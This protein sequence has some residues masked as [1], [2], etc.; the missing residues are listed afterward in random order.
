MQ[1]NNALHQGPRLLVPTLVD[2]MIVDDEVLRKMRGDWA[3]NQAE[4]NNVPH[5][6]PAFPREIA[7][8]RSTGRYPSVKAP[9]KG[10][11]L[12]WILPKGLCRGKVA[13]S[14]KL[15]F[16]LVPNRWLVL[17][18]YYDEQR[19][20]QLKGWVIR[21]DY[22]RKPTR[23][24][25]G[26]YILDEKE[27]SVELRQIGHVTPLEAWAGEQAYERT[28]LT[29]IGPKDFTFGNYTV[30]NKNV[31]S[32]HDDL[33][34]LREDHPYE[35]GYLV[36]GWFADETEDPL[37]QVAYGRE[38]LLEKLAFLKFDIGGEDG[39]EQ[40]EAAFAEAAGGYE[41]LSPLILCHGAIHSIRWPWKA[42]D[43]DGRPQK[44]LNDAD[45]VPDI[46]VGNSGFDTLATFIGQEL[47][48]NGLSEKETG[49][50][51]DLL[52]AF[53]QKLLK[54]YVKP[55]GEHQLDSYIHKSWFIGS[56]GGSYWE[57][58]QERQGDSEEEKNVLKQQLQAAL[59]VL[60]ELNE[61]QRALD[62][63]QAIRRSRL[64]QL[65]TAL[66]AAKKE[67]SEAWRQKALQIQDELQAISRE[68]STLQT[69]LGQRSS[70]VKSGL[71]IEE[72]AG[73]NNFAL[74]QYS[75]PNY[76]EPD[77]PVIL[78]HAAKTNDKHTFEHPP[79]CR[80]SGQWIDQ[81][82]VWDTGAT[83]SPDIPDL[84]NADN[85]PKE[86]PTL[87]KEFILLNPNF[88]AYYFGGEAEKIQKQQTLIWNPE[89]YAGLAPD[90]LL[91]RAGF[92][93]GKQAID[94][95]RPDFRSFTTFTLPWSPLFMD[96]VVYFFPDMGK[97]A[98]TDS[99]CSQAL[100]NWELP[101]DQMDYA[102]RSSAP[103]PAIDDNLRHMS[104]TIQGRSLISAHLPR[105][106]TAMLREFQEG[107]ADA[108]KQESIETVIGILSGFD[109]ITQRL[110][111]FN[112]YLQ[113]YDIGNQVPASLLKDEVIDHTLLFNNNFG[114]PM[115]D[116]VQAGNV[117]LNQYYPVR[118][119][120]LLVHHVRIVDEFGIG[121]YP[122]GRNEPTEGNVLVPQDNRLIYK[123]KGMDHSKIASTGLAQLTPRITQPAR[124]KMEWIDADDDAPV[125]QEAQNSPVCGWIIP[126]HLDKSLMIFDAAG[127]LQGSLVFFKRGDRYHIKKAVDPVSADPHRFAINNRHLA[128]FI[129]ELLALEDRDT[130]L[131]AFLEQI[132]KTTWI[133]DPLGAREKRGL[134]ALIGRPMALVRAE[135]Q[136][137]LQGLPLP[138][139]DFEQPTAYDIS[140]TPNPLGLM[141]VEF[142]YFLGSSILPGNGLIGYFDEVGGATDYR[143]F[144]VVTDHSHTDTGYITD[145]Q[146]LKAR[147]NHA[148]SAKHR[149]KLSLLLDYRGSVHLI[150][151]LLPTF[152]LRLAPKYTRD[153]LAKME[154]TFRTGPLITDPKQLRM[155]KP[156]DISGKLS[157]I[158]KSGVKIWQ[159]DEPLGE[160]GAWE[161]RQV[162]ETLA[163]AHYPEKRHQLSEGWLKL[164]EAFKKQS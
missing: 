74:K 28:R 54:D 64:Q 82:E 151:G 47:K 6:G 41:S 43:K 36:S 155:P 77:D 69:Q 23:R 12:Q 144:F 137:E 113:R 109:L 141:D 128:A 71:Y 58:V 18:T 133:T 119:G 62:R 131:S 117:K 19:R 135:V 78:V 57:I 53:D 96:W 114:M 46:I 44:N 31:F 149:R 157:W 159:E 150:S 7:V 145:Q 122:T 136:M 101:E 121:F 164:S 67:E 8:A 45:S 126:N 99:H 86:M 65:H 91:K 80:Y 63:Q 56:D 52:Y 106:L 138:A 97:Q 13:D 125:S 9:E 32:F 95:L 153:A 93:S 70:E 92:S 73:Q 90:R 158:Y 154:V 134:S 89:K 14:G 120:H 38:E 16:P 27:G 35:I 24:Y 11:H 26:P 76:W 108:K 79:R 61:V 129:N 1:I 132:D 29:A 100:E 102:L 34:D 25:D 51:S 147:L 72:G 3:R 115:G 146:R 163:N 55:G 49:F 160:S 42:R 148:L 143:K 83:F 48:E 88:A 139:F 39:L 104:W 94:A 105:V 161:N 103:V 59:P 10:V 111:G 60:A 140:A 152:E 130:A 124:L 50:V 127:K 15:E 110:S 37:Y 162:G 4:Y 40:A 87:V 22:V 30:N 75:A 33:A 116:A 66:F 85:I 107:L 84:P 5:F 17:R 21:S 123:G 142:P 112:E 81:M 2:A 68:M 98:M 20:P 118:S 156:N